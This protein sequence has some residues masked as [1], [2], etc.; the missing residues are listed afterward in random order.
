[1]AEIKPCLRLLL[2]VQVIWKFYQISIKSKVLFLGQHFSHYKSMELFSS[3]K[4]VSENFIE[5]AIKTEGA[6]PR[7]KSNTGPLNTQERESIFARCF[8]S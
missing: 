8:M 4:G 6:M 1:M 2:P 3:L 7:T 5:V